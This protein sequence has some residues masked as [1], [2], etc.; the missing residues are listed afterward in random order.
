MASTVKNGIDR[1]RNGNQRRSYTQSVVKLVIVKL[2]QY[3]NI[4]LNTTILNTRKKEKQD[5]MKTKTGG[6]EV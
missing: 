2:E 3:N 5:G 1:L 4:R 6:C